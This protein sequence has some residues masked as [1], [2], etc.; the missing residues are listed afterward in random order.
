MVS[1]DTLNV[2]IANGLVLVWKDPDPI[3]GNDYR[4]TEIVD[5]SEDML[6]IHYG[7]GSEAEILPSELLIDPNRVLWYLETLVQKE[8]TSYL[9][10]S[11]SKAYVFLY[12]Y[13]VENDINIPFGVEI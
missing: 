11:E 2:L 1:K 4:I 13:C 5:A 12:W 7:E 9:K 8:K 3:E 6:T 10:E